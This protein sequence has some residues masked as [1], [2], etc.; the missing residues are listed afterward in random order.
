MRLACSVSGRRSAADAVE[1]ARTAER[2]GYEEV[3]VTE[4]YC[5]RGAFAVAGAIA[6]AT[7]SVRIG[8]GVANPWTRH[9]V[10]LAMEA[11]ALD[12]VAG[13]RALLGL[14]ASNARWMQEQLGIPFE[15][16]LARLR[17]SVEVLRAAL[18]EGTV[19]HAGDAYRVDARLAFR[20]PR[21]DVPIVLGVKGWR[22]LELAGDVADGVLLSVLSSP[23]YVAW[24]RQRMG[25]PLPVSAYVALAADRDG[26]AAR[27][28]LRP[29][30]AAF[31]G[32]HG[33]HDITRV[34]GLSAEQCAAFRDGWREGRPRTDLVT[35]RILDTFAVAGTPRECAAAVRRLADAGLGTLVVMDDGAGDPEADLAS[36]RDCWARA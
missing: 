9:P 20:P 3:W 21:G 18:R 28:R 22:A 2:L 17:E 36:A 25:A 4:D 12:E 30:V 27:E 7:S 16:P 5:E 1:A 29:F 11:G 14:G 34:P 15:R 32:V 26:A 10:L 35:D 6:C 31:L 13:G 23:A 19:R 24:A 8:I 33:D